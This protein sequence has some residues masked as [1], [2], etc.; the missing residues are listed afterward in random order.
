MDQ[1]LSIISNNFLKKRV[2]RE[3][4]LLIKENTCLEESLNVEQQ[5]NNQHEYIVKFKN[6]KDENNYKFILPCN[7][8]FSAP[9]LRINEKNIAF[10]HR[11]TNKTFNESLRKYTGIVCFC[12]ETILCSNNWH[13][14][15][16]FKHVINDINRYKQARRQII[17]RLLIE[18][19]KRK[20]L[21]DDINI[22][23]WLY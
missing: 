1:K 23:E 10:Y 6:I 4:E 14:A 21:I 5:L 18:I 12:C 7:Y 22:I 19:I 3:I 11:I 16:T 15:F 2:K 13:P 17:D 9:K 8:P 20:Y